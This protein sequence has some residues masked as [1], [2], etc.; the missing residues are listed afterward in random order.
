[1]VKHVCL[2]EYTTD[3]GVGMVSN[4]MIAINNVL[5]HTSIVNQLL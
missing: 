2:Y 5:I 1:M 4:D 3:N